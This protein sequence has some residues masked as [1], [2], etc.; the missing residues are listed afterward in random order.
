MLAIMLD[1]RR[2]PRSMSRKEWREIDRWRRVTQRRINE[3]TARQLYN[4]GAYGTTHPE[5]YRDVMERIVN[6]P[7]LMGPYQ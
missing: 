4:L 2:F 7:M 3:E 5:I 1:I 6:P